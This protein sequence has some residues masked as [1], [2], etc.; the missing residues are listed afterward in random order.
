MSAAQR[1]RQLLDVATRL[2][3]EQGFHAVSVE[4]V[5]R[6][7]GITRAVIYQRFG[8]RQGLLEAVIRRE[9]SRALAQVT[10]SALSGLET[11]DPKELMLESLAAHLG[12]VRDHPTTWRLVLIPP[13]GAP[14]SLRRS[15]ARGQALILE[16]LTR[17]VR[18]A[19]GDGS[20]GEAEL[21]ARVLCAISDEYAR[22]LLTDP[23]RYPPERL[24]RHARRWLDDVAFAR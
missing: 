22:L 20:S 16:H 18:P 24:L 7:A 6:G 2:A 9:T 21:T 1:R 13:D 11:G 4:R 10:E 23:G 3:I 5:A 8:G 17:A 14:T 15:I 12:A 19:I